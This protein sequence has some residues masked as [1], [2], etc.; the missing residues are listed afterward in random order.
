MQKLKKNLANLI[1]SVRLIGAAVLVF[2]TPLSLP[3]HIVYTV[4][5]LSDALD[6][7]VARRLKIESR[8]GAR[9]D[10]AADL[11]FYLV[12]MLRVLPWLVAVLPGFIWIIVGVLCAARAVDYTYAAVKFHRFAAMHTVLNKL[13][14]FMM[15]LIPYTMGL[16][17]VFTVYGFAIC[18]VAAAAVIQ[19]L[20]RHIRM[21]PEDAARA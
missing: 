11:L 15:F 4:C 6:G 17:D 7:P 19:E 2:L 21:K 9:L 20:I 16:G 5:G 12:M 10:S 18:A 14:G 3:F 1:T 13:T 8:F